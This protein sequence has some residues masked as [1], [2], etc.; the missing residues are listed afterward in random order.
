MLVSKSKSGSLS[1]LDSCIDP[2][3]DPD[4]DSDLECLAPAAH[5]WA[6][7]KQMGSQVQNQQVH[8]TR[9]RAPVTC[10]VVFER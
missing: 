10:G 3:P 5:W 8:G 4:S 2:D 9:C 6:R 7:T 1:G